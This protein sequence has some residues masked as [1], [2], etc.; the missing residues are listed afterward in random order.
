VPTPGL[1]LAL[2]LVIS[3]ALDEFRPNLPLH[4]GYCI[5]F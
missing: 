4:R 2:F 3:T 1:E 5:N